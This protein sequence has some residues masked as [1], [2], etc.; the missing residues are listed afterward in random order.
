MV[1]RKVCITVNDRAQI[2]EH[3]VVQW[4]MNVGTAEKKVPQL[5]TRKKRMNLHSKGGE[6]YERT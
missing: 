2:K 5:I 4:Q 1:N 6:W 3:Q